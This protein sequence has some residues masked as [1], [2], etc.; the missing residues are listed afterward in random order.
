VPWVI[1]EC[2]ALPK[3][4]GGWGLKNMFLFTKALAGKGVWRLLTTTSLW[5]RVVHMK[6][7]AP[8]SLLDW[9]RSENKR[10]M[11][12]SIIWKVV[13]LSFDLIGKGL[14]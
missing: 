13:T 2:V 4:L 14:A 10:K 12:T 11:G 9:V 3:A 1:W 8:L 7:I 5:T 6:Y